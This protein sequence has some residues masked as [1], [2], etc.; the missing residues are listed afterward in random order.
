MR[1]AVYPGSFDPPTLG[2]LDIIRR[3]AAQFDRVIVCVMFNSEKS[4]LFTPAERVDLLRRSLAEQEGV[5]NV[6][7]D[8]DSGLLADY[9]RCVG[10][11]CLVKGLR[12]VADFESEMQMA[13]INRSLAPG[14]DTLF[15]T[16]RPELAFLSSTIVKELARYRV[17]LKG[18]VADAI[19]RDVQARVRERLAQT[20][21]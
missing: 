11:S 21:I 15:L 8:R 9:A 20:Q 6:T 14:L 12:R 10:A 3:A 16:A 2:H 7:V 5:D 4:G 17:D 1:I 18:A 13:D 19:E